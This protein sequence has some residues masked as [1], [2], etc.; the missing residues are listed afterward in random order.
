MYIVI[1][2][3][4]VY[5][6]NFFEYSNPFKF[7]YIN[8]IF[9]S[10]QVWVFNS[11]SMP[12]EAF[13]HPRD[14]FNWTATPRLDSD[15]PM[16]PHGIWMYFNPSWKQQ[17]PPP[18]V[19]ISLSLW[20]DTFVFESRHE[21]VKHLRYLPFKHFFSHQSACTNNCAYCIYREAERLFSI[22]KL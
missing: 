7:H 11:L 5:V 13:V 15:V 19:L 10:C 17:T 2:S 4:E 20:R 22:C 9:F 16:F 18:W 12:K 14:V 21:C 6:Y 1:K 8:T 3:A